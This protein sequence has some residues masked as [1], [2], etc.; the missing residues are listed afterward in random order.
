MASE[1][2]LKKYIMHNASALSLQLTQFSWPR[3]L[4][5][6]L[7]D[8][9]VALIY[10]DVSA[11]GR[12]SDLDPDLAVIKAFVEATERLIFLNSDWENTNGLAGHIEPQAARAAA[13]SELIER[14]IFFEHFVREWS[15]GIVD[16]DIGSDLKPVY[17][18][19]NH[20]GIR[21]RFSEVKVPEGIFSLCSLDGRYAEE[22]FGVIIGTSFALNGAHDKALV[23]A[24]RYFAAVRS[25]GFNT[26]SALEFEK[27]A[28]PSLS[29]HGSLGLD[30]SYASW[31]IETFQSRIP[32]VGY[33]IDTTALVV[34][35]IECP[36]RSRLMHFARAS[37]P[38]LIG[39]E[40]EIRSDYARLAA[41][42]R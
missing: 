8:V 35:D 17:Q 24:L 11:K 10:G 4:D 15:F 16:I 28:Q 23:E 32:K 42:F 39:L 21:A 22:P 18:T 25:K 20:L 26:I 34:E 29:D 27:I 30:P 3:E 36:F 31:F 19:L 5:L 38:S 33:R 7:E 13:K 14:H 41:P 37:S 2:Q 40:L 9:E 12:G 6:N 1:T